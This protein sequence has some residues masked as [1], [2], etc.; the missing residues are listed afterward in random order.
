MSKGI[1]LSYDRSE[2]SDRPDK[3]R[4]VAVGLAS[5]LVEEHG[6]VVGPRQLLHFHP[7]A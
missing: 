7:E 2:V 1:H 5:D 3:D 6:D 4:S